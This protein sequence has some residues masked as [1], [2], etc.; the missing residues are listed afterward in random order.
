M[1][2]E[3]AVRR[4]ILLIL[5]LLGSFLA[6]GGLIIQFSAG[7]SRVSNTVCSW[8]RPENCEAVLKE[9]MSFPASLGDSQLVAEYLSG[10]EGPFLEDGSNEE[11]VDVASLV[12]SNAGRRNI[13]SLQIMLYTTENALVFEATCIPAGQTVM[14]LEQNKAFFGNQEILDYKM[15][16]ESEPEGASS[17]EKIQVSETGMDTIALKNNGDLPLEHITV[18]HKGYLEPVRLLLGGI[19]HE[20]RIEHIAPGETVTVRLP[21]YAAGYSKIV[22]IT[23][24]KTGH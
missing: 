22:N 9:P 5:G 14:I 24:E 20:T 4:A 2:L 10:Y 3:I 16:F 17:F 15:S 6:A 21:Y 7:Q 11:V 23:A 19:T 18:C 1:M 8:E 12:V 13:R